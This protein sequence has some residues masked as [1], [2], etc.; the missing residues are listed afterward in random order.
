MLQ[1]MAQ[2]GS[3]VPA[4]YASLI[5]IFFFKLTRQNMALNT[6]DITTYTCTAQET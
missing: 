3:Y 6:S 4:E 5:S 2:I 1:I